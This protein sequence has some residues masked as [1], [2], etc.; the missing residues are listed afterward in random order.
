MAKNPLAIVGTENK[1]PSDPQ[2]C[3]DWANA[4]LSGYPEE[5]EWVVTG[6]KNLPIKL[7][8]KKWP[9]GRP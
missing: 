4:R 3:C 7:V 6:D 8:R 9:N 1:S 2:E 5:R